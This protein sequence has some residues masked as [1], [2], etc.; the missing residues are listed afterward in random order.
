[1]WHRV[2]R[3]P[4]WGVSPL[5]CAPNQLVSHDATKRTRNRTYFDDV[6]LS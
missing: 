6:R 1:V 3:P 2:R 4:R 5:I